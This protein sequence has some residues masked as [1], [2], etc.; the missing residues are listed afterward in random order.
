[1][2][3]QF[4]KFL[5]IITTLILAIIATTTYSQTSKQIVISIS[6][7]EYDDPNFA[8]LRETL[9]KNTKVKLVK[10]SYSSGT[11]SITLTYTSDAIQLWDE[12]PKS[13]KLFFKLNTIDDNSISLYY[14]KAKK[15]APSVDKTINATATN[16][17]CF[18]CDYFPLCKYDV[19][20]SYQGKIFRGIR[21]A[22][23]SIEYYFCDNGEL[24]KRWD[25][26]NVVK[27]QELIQGTWDDYIR[28][29]DDYEN[30]TASLVI[31]K[32]NVPIGTNW[33]GRVSEN[34]STYTFTLE[35][36]GIKLI[37]DGKT[38]S[39]VLRISVITSGNLRHDFHY[40]ARNTG[41][42]GKNIMEPTK[43]GR[44]EM[45]E[46]CAK[47]CGFWKLIEAGGKAIAP[48]ETTRYI[49]ITNEGNVGSYRAVKK[50]DGKLYTTEMP[51]KSSWSAWA[52][53]SDTAIF[54]D[55]WGWRG[56]PGYNAFVSGETIGKNSVPQKLMTFG[57]SIY[58]YI[59]PDIQF[60]RGY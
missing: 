48:E 57:T 38:Y 8:S 30:N 60:N 10:P 32:S 40:Y 19:V 27:K 11:A 9:K 42:I 6:G 2:K 36:K 33:T 55:N 45:Y 21:N 4:F 56:S 22:N 20:K 23:N 15:S 54:F 13:S 34:G 7:I 24:I 37:H 41:Y 16:K 28:T 29:Y 25:Y 12:I 31:M 49:E 46:L 14:T 5:S 3:K 47:W 53:E 26:T 1:M 58:E 17:G 51:M 18:D 39:D 43:L 44:K 35:A 59:G 52:I 50:A